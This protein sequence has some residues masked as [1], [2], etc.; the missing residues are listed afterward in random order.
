MAIES[1]FDRTVNAD[2]ST[3]V[4]WRHTFD[5]AGQNAANDWIDPADP[6]QIFQDAWPNLPDG[7]T[8]G[9]SRSL[10][11]L[12]CRPTA[13]TWRPSISALS[14]ITATLT[15]EVEPDIR[16]AIRLVGDDDFIAL[17]LGTD[18]DAPYTS[19]VV[20]FASDDLSGAD[21]TARYETWLARAASSTAQIT[22]ALVD[23]THS[24][25]DSANFQFDDAGADL[26]PTAPT[27][28][29]Q[30]ATV[31][32]AFS[33][34]LL[35]ATG[36]DTPITTTADQL[37][38][39]LTLT[40]GVIS[41]TPTTAGTTTVTITYSDADNDTDTDSFDIAVA[42]APPA[43]LMPT[44]PT[45]PDQ[46]ATVGTAF[47][48]TLLAATGG[49]TPITTTADQLP[50]GLTLT[51]GVISGTPTTV[52]TTTVTITYSDA[53]NDTDTDS[54]DIAVAAAPPADLM[55]TAG[56]TPDETGVVGTAFSVTVEAASG[57]DAPLTYSASGLASWMSFNA[58]T[59]VLSGTPDAAGTTTVRIT[60]E[61][62]DGDTDSDTFAVAIA[63]APP[64]SRPSP[65]TAAVQSPASFWIDVVTRG[66]TYGPIRDVLA[67]QHNEIW[68][69]GG[70]FSF[71][72]VEK[73]AAAHIAEFSEIYAYAMVGGKP[74]LVGAGF[75]QNIRDHFGQTETTLTVNGV[76]FEQ[77]LLTR[78]GVDL[79]FASTSHED[80]VAALAA[81]LPAGWSLLPDPQIANEIASVRIQAKSMLAAIRK[82][83]EL[84]QTRLQ[85]GFDRTIQMRTS[86]APLN[87]FASED[88]AGG[89]RIV[90]PS[91]IR[92]AKEVVT[93]LRPFASDRRDR[94]HQATLAAPDGFL[95]DVAEGTV[96]HEAA[97]DAYGERCQE[98]VFRSLIPDDN[99]PTARAQTADALLLLSVAR[100]KEYGQPQETYDVTIESPQELL[101]PWGLLDVSIRILKLQRTFR[102]AS[103]SSTLFD[104]VRLRQN[105]TLT[106][107]KSVRPHR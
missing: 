64:P 3:G 17:R 35:A 66:V 54:F 57:G 87:F 96:T 73:G 22:V 39:G 77:E 52:G 80:V 74:T 13:R 6:R 48:Y 81:L 29:D 78:P 53:D 103:V 11:L 27:N 9:D 34:T 36:G 12:R 85:F 65:A 28:P 59:R 16:I 79:S 98:H 106:A 70:R 84:F 82:C 61:D 46:T 83:A 8:D 101:R 21:I 107:Q 94:L 92:D 72:V 4:W 62:D 67:W 97:Y 7:I 102:V 89:A 88:G 91:R 76:G 37:P 1:V 63:A 75:V 32:T 40:N 19:M 14:L 58:A 5:I 15:N 25:F 99:S 47:S 10:G 24:E 33:Y 42:A 18:T 23:S 90:D 26:M 2:G 50:A 105:T 93:V 41:G 49:D 68:A 71:T 31:G 100:L 95:V 43:D 55:P 104:G 38:A 60:V 56:D 69:E 20:D 45:N 44:A 51:N 30:T 86:Y